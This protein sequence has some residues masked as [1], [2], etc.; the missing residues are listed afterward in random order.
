MSQVADT[1]F[2]NV[3]SRK[4]EQLAFTWGEDGEAI[5]SHVEGSRASVALSDNLSLET[6]LM[7]QIVDNENM[8]LARK[9][10]CRNKGSAGVDG[11]SVDDLHVHLFK[12]W[13]TIKDLLLNGRYQP[14]PVKRVDIPKSNGGTRT[15]GIPTV[16]DR[17]IQQAI[18]QILEPIYDHTFSEFSYGFRP[19]RNAHQALNTARQYVEDGYKVVVDID[20]EKFFDHVNHDKLMSILAMKI[21]DKRLLKLIRSFLQAG[22]MFHGVK[23]ER[24]E[25]TPQGG[26]LSP[27]LSNI[28]LNELDTELTCR[29]HRFCRYA[30]DCNIYVKSVRAGQR[31]MSSV[32]R[33]LNENL[34]LRINEDKS[35]VAPTGERKFLGMRIADFR[36]KIRIALAPESIKRVR[37]NIRK[38]TKRNRGIS[39]KRMLEELNTAMM[40]WVNYYY[41]SMMHDTIRALDCNIRRR[42]RCFIW[43]QWKT[44]EN[45]VNHLQSA[46]IDVQHSVAL[47][48]GKHGLWRIAGSPALQS[49][50]DNKILAGYGLKS[51][52]ERYKFLKSR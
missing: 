22:I 38:I 14:S 2:M 16:T 24:H 21:G 4:P 11:M 8:K 15:L 26:P 7:E 42:I 23:T 34:H 52:E 32:K 43:K 29:K 44:Y 13:R 30:D 1:K 45:R 9:R 49:T 31:V 40:G 28:I 6:N 37:K 20:I 18:L 17:L 47:G 25:G 46:G 12:N 33:W 39:L 41:I 36:G 3:R 27:L 50:L 10:V 19:C 35:G 51:L 5:E 48:A